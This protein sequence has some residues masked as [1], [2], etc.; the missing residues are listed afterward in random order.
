MPER[1]FEGSEK[2]V[3]LATDRA[4]ILAASTRR[5]SAL[6]W[7]YSLFM[8]RH[9]LQRMWGSMPMRMPATGFPKASVLV[10][11]DLEAMMYILEAWKVSSTCL[12]HVYVF[13]TRRL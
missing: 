12:A 10:G 4:M 11:R 8:E 6:T 1:R 13:G 9:W 3:L 7:R 5:W 2:E